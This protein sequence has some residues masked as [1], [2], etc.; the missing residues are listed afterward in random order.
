MPED[1]SPAGNA[2]TLGAYYTDAQV[3]DF[4]VQWAIRG[5][6]DTVLDP[7][8]GGGVFLRSACKRLREL[9]GDP[10]AQVH[11]VEIDASVHSR[12]TDKLADE[13]G[14]DPRNLRH[15]DFFTETPNPVDVVVGNP[16]FIR[17]QRFTGDLRRRALARAGEHGIPLSGL[18]SSWLPFLLCGISQ[19][20]PQGRLAMVIPV[21]LAHASYA[22]PALEI[23]S[24]SFGAVTI[25]TFRKK[26]FPDLSEDTLLLLA[27]RKGERSARFH[28]R[29]L[30]HAG[31]LAGLAEAPLRGTRSLDAQLLG[32]GAERLIEQVLPQK[33]R[34]LYRELRASKLAGK[35]GE[36]AS[37]GIGYVTGAND[38]FHLSPD[39]VRTWGIPPRFLRP[40]V[41]RGRSLAGVQFTTADWRRA[42][43]GGETG[44]LLLVPPDGKVPGT[45]ARYLAYGQSEGVDQAYKCRVRTPWYS[46]PQVH[47]PDAFL[48]YMSGSTPHLVANHAR[49]V[50]PNSL[51]GL[52]MRPGSPLSADAVA[53]LWH[54]SLTRLSTELAGHPLGGGM[55]KL[56]PAEA[57]SVVIATPRRTRDIA[58]LTVA[59][60]GIIRDEGE[61]AA[62]EHADQ[63]VLQREL[64]LTG[65]DCKLL[66]EA[67]RL[68][69]ER[70]TGRSRAT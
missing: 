23:L 21:E 19:L 32:R 3:A 59:L 45:V 14:L 67:A 9:E 61:A 57:E 7:A 13:F 52:R 60:D 34:E 53:G 4:L 66:R 39:G 43:S 38:F 68:L 35:L 51:L 31:Q 69:R 17:Y 27:E 28:W 25:L 41:R 22:R 46:V 54:T 1:A 30:A 29:D 63:A 65:R 5:P 12:I 55:L 16:P 11:G 47:Q 49:A 70:R 26:L 6:A 18:S 36:H 24:R 37:I 10:S 44:Y 40:A 56:E 64:G 62:A 8:F 15:G 42:L 50:A 2:K 33:A 48:S 58:S 20:R